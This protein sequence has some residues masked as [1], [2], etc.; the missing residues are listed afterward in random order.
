MESKQCPI[1][2]SLKDVTVISPKGLSSIDRAK[3]DGEKEIEKGTIA[4][5]LNLKK[6][7]LEETRDETKVIPRAV[8]QFALNAVSAD[9]IQ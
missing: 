9:P 6:G 1:K 7:R 3:T 5:T 2:F 8:R 4:E